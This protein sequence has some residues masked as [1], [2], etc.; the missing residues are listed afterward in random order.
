[1]ALYRV[2]AK[3]TEN[4][5]GVKLEKGMSVEVS[6]DNSNPIQFT[7]GR[8][9]IRDAFLRIYGIDVN[10]FLSFYSSYFEVEKLS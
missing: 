4:R 9:A 1:M 3:K 5:S 7:K 8:T 6:H 10:G 2:T